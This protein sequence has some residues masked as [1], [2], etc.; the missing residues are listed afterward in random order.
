MKDELRPESRR[1]E[2]DGL[3]G[4][5]GW[6]DNFHMRFA[7]ILL[8][9][10]LWCA[11]AEPAPK[12]KVFILAGQSNMEG[13]AVVDLTG[14]DYNEGKGTLVEVM[15]RPGNA[16][17][18]AHLRDKDGK[19]VVRQDV[20]VRY[21]REKQSL[22]S[23]GLSVGYA[24]YGGKHHF[25]PEFQF[26][27]VVGEAYRDQV[28]LIKTSWGGKSL[29]RDFRP[30]SAGGV[31][32]PYYLKM[33][34]EVRAAL[35]NLKKDFPAY[36]G[37]PV[38][39]AGFVWYQGWNDGVNP[40]TAVPEYE[41]N[42]VHLIRDVRK[43]FG[44]P[45]LPVI[46]GELTGAWV[47]APKEWTALRNAQAAV[48]K[49]P[50]FKDNVVFVP[51]R[52]F[53]R[54]A[55][56]SPNPGHGH[57]EFGNAE[58]YFLVGDALGKAAVQMAGRDRQVRELRGW[59]LRIDER[60]ITKDAAMVEKAVGMLDKHL[61]TIIRL[62]PAKAVAELKK[63]TLNFTLP[64]STRSTA[65]YH[66][67]LEWIKQSG[68]EIAL[69][70]S[71]EFTNVERFEFETK[72]MPVFVL[73]ELAHAYH[74]KFVPGGYQNPDILGAYQKAKASG[75]YDAVKRWTGEK[76]VDKPAKAYAMNNQ[77]EYFA[78]STESYFDRNDFEPFNR[79]ELL[80]KDPAMLK[81]VEKVWGIAEK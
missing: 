57:H 7:P 61:E 69:A 63:T 48:A 40:K 49:R 50:E 28:L 46:V 47:D 78:E 53:V 59:T 16:D 19:W 3:A 4:R 71:V 74:D 31:V 51:T 77:M 37:S 1:R 75:T 66:G 32:G 56:D 62:V 64:Y 35:A 14:R 39:L 54:K 34:A 22:L 26:G 27:H 58:T 73:H 10:S 43:E 18:Y 24:V 45:K 44:A 17:R 60:L 79:A 21:Q 8:C 15:A 5:R 11:A 52:D 30:P 65:E 68:R 20:W 36:D 2:G 38:E 42:L 6:A 33:V 72:R 76:L 13:Q 80:A 23:G 41:Q 67:G 70:K 81:V 29:Y 55:E 25:G 9:W 12:L